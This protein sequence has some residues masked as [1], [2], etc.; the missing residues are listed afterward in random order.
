MAIFEGLRQ[1][2]AGKLKVTVISSGVTETELGHDITDEASATFVKEGRKSALP[3]EVIANAM[4]YAIE[5]PDY[6]DVSEVIVREK[7]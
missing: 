4:A 1:E 5:Q 2:V 7:G 6:V 3:P